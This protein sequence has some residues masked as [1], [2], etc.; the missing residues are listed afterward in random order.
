MRTKAARKWHCPPNRDV[1]VADFFRPVPCGIAIKHRGSRPTT[2]HTNARTHPCACER[3]KPQQR[4]IIFRP[5]PSFQCHKRHKPTAGRH[6]PTA[7]RTPQNRARHKSLSLVE[8]G[9]LSSECE[10]SN[11]QF[12]RSKTLNRAPRGQQPLHL[13]EKQ[14]E[15][16][17]QQNDTAAYYYARSRYVCPRAARH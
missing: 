8:Q 4:Y 11:R 7:G 10:D 16:R 17:C 6:K 1:T 14:S 13:G 3:R 2:G 15:A 9:A 12:S 5:S